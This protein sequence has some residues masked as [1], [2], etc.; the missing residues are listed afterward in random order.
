MV[1]KAIHNDEKSFCQLINQN[2][3]QI[4]KIA[5]SYVNNKEDALDIVQ[6]AVTKAYVS[7]ANL[8]EPEFF[9]TWLIRIVIN[10]AINHLN[11]SK[12]IIYVDEYNF[13][14]VNNDLKNVEDVI[15]L[16]KAL[17][18]LDVKYK[19]VVILKYFEDKTLEEIS[20]ILNLPLS[21]VK[22]HL[23]RALQKLKINLKEE[24]SI[25]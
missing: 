1:M 8:K 24:E 15:D 9:N 4:Y 5:Y 20:N 13:S 12:K 10:C 14:D 2:K 21:T 3:E 19:T 7:I 23:Y 22:T 25:E 17:D 18:E 6:D 11:K 16:N